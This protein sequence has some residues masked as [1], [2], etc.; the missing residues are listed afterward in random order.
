MSVVDPATDHGPWPLGVP[1]TC[2]NGDG[3]KTVVTIGGVAYCGP[4]AL[5]AVKGRDAQEIA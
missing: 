1:F 3:G 2:S 4:C 5:A